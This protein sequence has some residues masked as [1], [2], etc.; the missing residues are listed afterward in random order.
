MHFILQQWVPLYRAS[1][2][3][4]NTHTYTKSPTVS[5]STAFLLTFSYEICLLLLLFISYQSLFYF[6]SCL[7]CP[8]LYICSSRKHHDYQPN[9]FFFPHWD[10]ATSFLFSQCTSTQVHFYCLIFTL[11]LKAVKWFWLSW[12]KSIG[13]VASQRR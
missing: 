9:Y 3:S 4:V 6:L 7:A 8:L 12:G 1:S 5:D 10:V 11:C 2:F 13:F